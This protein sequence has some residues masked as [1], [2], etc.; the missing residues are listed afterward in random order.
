M[1][2]EPLQSFLD[3]GTSFEGKISFSGEVRIDGYFK[4][5]ASAE[6][7]L[8]VGET[9]VVEADIELRRLVVHGHFTGSVTAKEKVEI[10]A[11]GRVDGDI[12]AP[13]FVLAEGGQIS[14]NVRMGEGA[15]PV[16]AASSPATG[17]T[18]TAGTKGTTKPT[19]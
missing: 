4:G 18:G 5:E 19:T 2:T 8:V 17:A 11:T 14:G 9:G 15:R 7:T 3:Q 16:V 12:S 6:G 13:R 1:S 10:S